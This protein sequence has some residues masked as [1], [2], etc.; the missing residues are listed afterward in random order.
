MGFCLFIVD[1]L[2][3]TGGGL[4]TS[5]DSC[6]P[7]EGNLPES[8]GLWISQ[9]RILEQVAISFSRVSSRLR[10]GTHVSCIAVSC[11]AGGLFTD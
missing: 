4:V 5:S 1:W 6:D 3:H 11:T 8:S 2:A 9:A 7:M 10:D